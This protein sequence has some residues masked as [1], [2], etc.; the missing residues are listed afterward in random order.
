MFLTQKHSEKCLF[1]CFFNIT[2]Q[3]NNI[4]KEF[5]SALK[6]NVLLST[7]KVTK[8]EHTRGFDVTQFL[9]HKKQT[10]FEKRL[11]TTY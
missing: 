2:F 1:V 6:V 10:L 7:Y 8:T 5:Q 4:Q 9:C 3:Y 11:I